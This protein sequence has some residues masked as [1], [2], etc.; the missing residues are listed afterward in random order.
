[1]GGHRG[2]GAARGAAAGESRVPLPVVERHGCSAQV[3]RQ[4]HLAAGHEDG[5]DL[6]WQGGSGTIRPL[7]TIRMSCGAL[8]IG[9]EHGG[10]GTRLALALA[11]WSTTAARS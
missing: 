3:R 11:P 6:T 4:E 7:P 10:S 1:R 9:G 8:C 5:Q 2:R